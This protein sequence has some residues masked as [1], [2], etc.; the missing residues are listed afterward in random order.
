MSLAFAMLGV[1]RH[2]LPWHLRAH[3]QVGNAPRFQW[4]DVWL[5]VGPTPLDSQGLWRLPPW[6]VPGLTTHH[7]QQPEYIPGLRVWP[8][9]YVSDEQRFL[10]ILSSSNSPYVMSPWLI[11]ESFCE[12]KI[13][14]TLPLQKW[15]NDRGMSA[16][17][18]KVSA[19]SA[20]CLCLNEIVKCLEND[21]V[22]CIWS[23]CC[24]RSI[25]K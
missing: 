3:T 12:C 17:L 5:L 6:E 18:Q 19:L 9:C 10:H 16:G 25:Q 11:S 13:L 7:P 21:L 4:P 23:M 14:L 20:F 24:I 15:P 2:E 22:F 1:T 8:R